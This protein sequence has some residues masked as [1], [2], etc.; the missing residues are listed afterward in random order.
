MARLVDGEVIP[1]DGVALEPED[2]DDG[3]ILT[4]QATPSSGSLAIEFD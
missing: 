1:G 3:Y 4:C 2:I